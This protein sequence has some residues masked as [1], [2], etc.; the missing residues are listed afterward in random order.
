[1]QDI[2]SQARALHLGIAQWT[3][4]NCC[5]KHRLFNPGD[6]R[7]RSIAWHERIV[8]AM[9]ERNTEMAVNELHIHMAA[10]MEWVNNLVK[11]RGGDNTF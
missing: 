9:R 10:S 6:L 2:R 11:E 7:S 3:N 8:E 5:L 1:M 4:P